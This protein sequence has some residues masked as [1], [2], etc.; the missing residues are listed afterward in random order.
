MGFF[1]DKSHSKFPFKFPIGSYG[2]FK[3]EF[4]VELLTINP[5]ENSPLN[6]LVVLWEIK[7][8]NQV[9]FFTKGIFFFP[10]KS[11]G[12]VEKNST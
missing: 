8:E 9:E 1:F 7:G 11:G 4:Q 12:V 3:G 6:S 5:I 2:K 10:F